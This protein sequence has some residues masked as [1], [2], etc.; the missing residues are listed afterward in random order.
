VNALLVAMML[1]NRN[2]SAARHD[3][4]GRVRV[5]VG[6]QVKSRSSRLYCLVWAG[7]GGASSGSGLRNAE[8]LSFG[9]H[10]DLLVEKAVQ[11]A[12]GGGVLGQD[13]SPLVEGPV[14]TMPRARR[15]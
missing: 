6:G 10:D 8:R 5:A 13:P 3:V 2:V 15:S 1:S 4:N 14:G 11:H 12:D 9:G 7:S